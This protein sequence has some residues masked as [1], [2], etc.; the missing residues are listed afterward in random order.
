MKSLFYVVLLFLISI[1][2]SCKIAQKPQHIQIDKLFSE[3]QLKRENDSVSQKQKRIRV[4]DQLQSESGHDSITKQDVLNNT[5]KS[6][7]LTQIKAFKN[8]IE[9]AINLPINE[10]KTIRISMLKPSSS[11]AGFSKN[12]N[13]ESN[14][15]SKLATVFLLLTLAMI[16]LFFIGSGTSLALVGV[17][18]LLGGLSLFLCLLFFILGLV[19]K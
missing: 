9:T 7:S 14:I 18:I 3:Q 10:I 2:S 17:A 19:I 5:S 4:N 12:A 8:H 16:V 13:V 11:A 6:E 15:Y 1:L